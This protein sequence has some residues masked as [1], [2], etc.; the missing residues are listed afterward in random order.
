MINEKEYDEGVLKEL[1][2]YNEIY[3]Q[4]NRKKCAL[5]PW[6]GFEKVVNKLVRKGANVFTN[7]GLFSLHS[8][9]HPSKQEL[10]LMLK[11]FKPKYCSNCGTELDD[12]D[13]FCSSCGN[14]VNGDM[15]DNQNIREN[16]E[17]L[18]NK[19]KDLIT[20]EKEQK[21][22]IFKSKK[23]M[24]D[25]YK[26][27]STNFIKRLIYAVLLFFLPSIVCEITPMPEFGIIL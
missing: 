7:G 13:K 15:S 22:G 26:S 23:T 9:G 17:N 19:E 27:I 14:I 6:W 3:K 12:S 8:S 16:N 2:V 20:T 24:K 4:P 1:N 25:M 21:G 5:L 18:T 11:L 10:R